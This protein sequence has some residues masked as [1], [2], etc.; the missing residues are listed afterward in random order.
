[1]GVDGKTLLRPGA[2][3]QV[4]L[5]F[6]RSGVVKPNSGIVGSLATGVLGRME[7]IFADEL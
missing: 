1:M 4:G 2:P 5:V 3:G 6:G 7:F